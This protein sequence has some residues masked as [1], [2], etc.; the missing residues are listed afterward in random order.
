MPRGRERPRNALLDDAILTAAERQLRER[1]FTG[2]SIESVASSA[3]TTVPTL[4]RRYN[5]KLALAEAVIDSMRVEPLQ[6]TDGAPRARALAILE[7]FARNL[8]RPDSMA[9]LGTLL[10]EEHRNAQLIGRFRTRLVAPRRALLTAVVREAIVEGDLP[11]ATD[12]EIIVNLLIG[13]FYARYV[14][15]GSIP[16][17]WAVRALEQV[18]PLDAARMHTR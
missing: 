5:D 17:N 8:R 12:A 10:A 6:A 11:P 7:N 4:R 2:M 15:R 14:S 18:W 13:S 1:G 3:G 16:R 9:L